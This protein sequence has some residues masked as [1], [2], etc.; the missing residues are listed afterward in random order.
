ML[1]ATGKWIVRLARHTL[2]GS[3]ACG[4]AAGTVAI[5]M[6]AQFWTAFEPIATTRAVMALVWGSGLALLAGSRISQILWR[7]PHFWRV[8]IACSGVA[9]WPSLWKAVVAGQSEVPLSWYAEYPQAALAV[10]LPCLTAGLIPVFVGAC[11]YPA[12]DSEKPD[13]DWK[14]LS[15]FGWGM[16]LSVLILPTTLFVR[17]G[18]ESILLGSAAILTLGAGVSLLVRTWI[19]PEIPAGASLG[20]FATNTASPA[21]GGGSTNETD[22]LM[23]NSTGNGWLCDWGML[24]CALA[25]GYSL[26]AAY[27]SS[28]QLVIGV[29]P[30][31]LFGWGGFLAGALLAGAQCFRSTSR[32]SGLRLV[33]FLT[34]I[35]T[36]LVLVLFPF[37]IRWGVWSSASL[38]QM[39]KIVTA[40]GIP[41]ASI[42]FPFGLVV[43]SLIRHSRFRGL[44]IGLVS[45]GY[46][47][48]V[49]SPGAASMTLAIVASAASISSIVLTSRDQWTSM[50]TNRLMNRPAARLALYAG[51]IVASGLCTNWDD[52]ARTARLLFSG[53][54]FSAVGQG[55]DLLTIERSDRS[56][57]LQ[58]IEGREHVW[59]FWRH[60]G[61]QILVRR[62]GVPLQTGR[63]DAAF[64]PQS[65]WP[66]MTTTAP[67]VIHRRAEH[68]LCLGG[69]GHVE[70][71]SLLSFPLKSLTCLDASGEAKEVIQTQAALSG[72]T[73][74]FQDGRLEWV[75]A[76]P[77]QFALSK[78]ET[79]YDLILD[80][81][82]SIVALSRQPQLT[83]EYYSHIA[84]HLRDD[85]LFSQRINII[86]F[87]AAPVVDLLS[88]ICH[89][90]P[91]SIILT[92]DGSELLIV[93]SRSDY[94]LL[95]ADVIERMEKSHVRQLC[96]TMGADWSVLCQFAC[97]SPPNVEAISSRGKG[98]SNSQ[99]N[100]RWTM[101]LGAETLRWGPKWREK[102][103]LFSDHVEAFLTA[104][105]QSEESEQTIARRIQDSQERL[106]ILT[107]KV[108]DQWSYRRS[109]RDALKERPR[110]TIQKV[111]HEIR[112]TLIDDDQHRKNYL[113]VLGQAVRTEQPSMTRIEKL[114]NFT[115]PYDPLITD[116]AHFEVAHLLSRH[117]DTDPAQQ[118]RHW[119]HCITYAPEGDRSTRPV[120]AAMQLLV[121]H[122][123]IL[124]DT[125]WRWDQSQYLLEIMRH[126]WTTRWQS[127]HRSKYEEAD[128]QHSIDAVNALMFAMDSQHTLADIEEATW[129]VQQRMWK[130]TLVGPLRASQSG[131][132][133]RNVLLESV[134]QEWQRKNA[135]ATS[136]E[137]NRETER[138]ATAAQ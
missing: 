18:A 120:T 125:S 74:S 122:P 70:L 119:M 68:V 110:T 41:L 83:H 38:S 103:D 64:G 31:K 60:R 97:M 76:T 46:V 109:L 3:L 107:E 12:N 129:R 95:S 136:S 45:A 35:S 6:I 108:E 5:A 102:R 65:F 28:H 25:V 22:R 16:V 42:L 27:R 115:A 77:H 91:Q 62:D 118:Y 44:S 32:L 49:Y 112:K 59:T 52:P 71:D 98:S 81:D 47:C 90:F 104:L 128:L 79:Q 135:A 61:N 14:N 13:A 93:A 34:S 53:E 105:H 8:G 2:T 99:R 50:W 78:E 69:I 80:C 67:M 48:G 85:G 130:E 29:L 19:T 94:P 37:W 133:P 11:L 23:E 134:R 26:N 55:H 92:T 7:V 20:Q 124:S 51:V 132:G 33:L 96:S 10:A 75:S 126:R 56:R 1:Y 121:D 123:E 114:E 89:V 138:S 58:T 43:G 17:V 82:P 117:P 15:A 86:D 54:V 66:I 21:V 36:V 106:R 111:N 127:G 73:P 57:W 72:Q 87:G 4:L 116:F 84:R 39:W 88:S 137:F 100:T 131:S 30:L 9:C 113:Q 63:M 101:S 24:V 40:K